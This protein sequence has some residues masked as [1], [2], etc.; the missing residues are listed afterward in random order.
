MYVVKARSPFVKTLED[1]V[2]KICRETGAECAKEGEWFVIPVANEEYAKYVAYVVT[3]A[4]Q[5]KMLYSYGVPY[6]VMLID[7]RVEQL[8]SNT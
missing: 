2:S 6:Q 8:N 4:F 1:V 3:R 5:R 7:I